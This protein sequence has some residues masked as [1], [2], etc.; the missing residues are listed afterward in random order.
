MSSNK[1]KFNR[2]K[3]LKSDII[4]KYSLSENDTG[5]ALVQIALF[6]ERIKYLTEHLQSNKKDKHS[7]RGLLR[8]VGER[9]RMYKYAL[10]T[11]T[12]KELIQKINMAMGK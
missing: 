6:T 5:S 12:D 4:R 7:R 11:I 9:R 8:L 2:N 10:K 3:S 1:S